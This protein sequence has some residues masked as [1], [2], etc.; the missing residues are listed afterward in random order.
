MKTSQRQRGGLLPHEPPERNSDETPIQVEHVGRSPEKPN[1]LP[2]QKLWHN[3]QRMSGEIRCFGSLDF[4]LAFGGIE[5]QGEVDE[6]ITL[7]SGSLL[8]WETRGGMAARKALI[9][10]V[11]STFGPRTRKSAKT[12]PRSLRQVWEGP[13]WE[14]MWPFLE[15]WDALEMRATASRW[16]VPGQYRP[17]GEL[18]FMKKEP[19]TYV[20]VSWGRNIFCLQ[21]VS[22]GI[23][24]KKPACLSRGGTS[25]E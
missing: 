13:C 5:F 22:V 24:V 14:G 16:N 10:T 18:F 1:R 9:G 3:V 4:A 21:L 8:T 12:T 7:S 11:T 19:V 17:H 25:S 15:P 20:N 6:H 23:D 2:W